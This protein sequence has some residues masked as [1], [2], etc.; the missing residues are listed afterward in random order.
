MS[1]RKPT[2]SRYGPFGPWPR[3]SRRGSF[4]PSTLRDADRGRP[5]EPT[6]RSPVDAEAVWAGCAQRGRDQRRHVRPI[7]AE[8][9]RV[10]RHDHGRGFDHHARRDWS[11]RSKPSPTG[12]SQR[13]L[14]KPAGDAIRGELGKIDV[15]QVSNFRTVQNGINAIDMPNF[16][17]AHTETTDAKHRVAD[18]QHRRCRP[19]QIDI[20]QG[21]NTLRFG[22]VNVDYTPPGGTPLNADRTRTTSSRSPWGCRSFR[23]RASSSTRSTATPQRIRPRARA[24]PGLRDIPRHGPVESL[25]GQLDHGQHDVGTGPVAVPQPDEP[26][27]R[28]RPGGTYVIS[29]GGAGHGSDR[30]RAGRRQRDQLHDLRDRGLRSTR[31]R[32]KA[33]STPRSATSTSAARPTTCSWSPRRARATSRSAWAWTTSRSIA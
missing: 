2:A 29:Q 24:L 25:P 3:V 31:R 8:P 9:A 32:R 18:S 19:V 26:P 17:L 6:R 28:R 4:S 21:V 20:P 11:A 15:G 22:G 1:K 12:D 30:Q 16:Y 13:L 10:D 33:S 5:R 27:R 7:D 23:G 14:R